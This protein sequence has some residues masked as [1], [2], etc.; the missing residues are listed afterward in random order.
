MK[1]MIQKFTVIKY[2]ISKLYSKEV[3]DI[4]IIQ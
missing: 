2:M 4:K 3:Y 1:Y